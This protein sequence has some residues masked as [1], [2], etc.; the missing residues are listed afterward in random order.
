MEGGGNKEEK[1][2]KPEKKEGRRE[3]EG[4]GESTLLYHTYKLVKLSFFRINK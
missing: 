1:K 2:G 4:G 3:G